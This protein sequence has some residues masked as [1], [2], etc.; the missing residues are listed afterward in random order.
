MVLKT[1]YLLGTTACNSLKIQAVICSHISLDRLIYVKF[2]K[3]CLVFRNL[4][5]LLVV[6]RLSEEQRHLYQLGGGKR[7]CRT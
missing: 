5:L 3:Q 6:M 1:F 2:R 4:Q 7:F